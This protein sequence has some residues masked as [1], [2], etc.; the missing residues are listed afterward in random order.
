MSRA[1]T[2][3][4]QRY[5]SDTLPQFLPYKRGSFPEDSQAHVSKGLRERDTALCTAF[6]FMQLASRLGAPCERPVGIISDQGT[7]QGAPRIVV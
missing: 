6:L 4:A 2:L 5:R 7:P 3:F 1:G